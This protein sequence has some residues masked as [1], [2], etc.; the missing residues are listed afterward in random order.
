[1]R[2]ILTWHSVDPSGSPISISPHDFRR[3][4]DW[5]ASGQV[6]VVSVGELLALPEGAPAVALT[7]DDGFVSFATEAAPLLLERHLPVTLFV[8]TSHVGRDN[9]WG[10]RGDRGVPVLPLLDWDELGRLR[11]IGITVGAHTQTH[12]R[13]TRLDMPR[14]EQELWVAADEIE[15]R[16]GQPPEGLAYP[17]G[18]VDHRVAEVAAARYRWAC[19]TEL[20]PFSGA[21]LPYRLPRLDAW[22]FRDTSRLVEWGSAEFRARLWCR[23]QGRRL[24]SLTASVTSS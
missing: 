3:Q 23:R 19:T 9:R 6:P 17:Y 14:L 13:L 12:P 20:R 21:E 15:R 18:V 8:V 22:Y 11:E 16:M 24:K 7:F 2:A 5:L 4:V 1:M 10:G